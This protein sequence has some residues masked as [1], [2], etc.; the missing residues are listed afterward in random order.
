M[1]RIELNKSIYN[2]GLVTQAIE[3]FDN[4]CKIKIVENGNYIE[5][6]FS[7]CVYDED[8]TAKEFENYIIDLLNT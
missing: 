5:C 3:A 2:T 1:K 7:N 6:E 4:L 8:T